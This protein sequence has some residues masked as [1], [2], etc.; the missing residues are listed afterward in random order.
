MNERDARTRAE[1]VGSLLRSPEVQQAVASDDPSATAV[2]D[3]AVLAAIELQQSAGLDVI[4][5]GETRRRSWTE[6]PRYLDCFESIAN[7]PGLR[8]RG[9]SG[10]AGVPAAGVTDVVVRRVSKA[11]RRGDRTAQYAFLAGHATA[12]TKF[13]L[14]APSYHRRYWSDEYSRS[15][16]GS[17]EEFLEEVRDHLRSVVAELISLGCDYIQC[18]APN[19]GSLCDAEHRAELTRQGHDIDAELAFDAALDNSLFDGVSG[20][21]RALHICRGNAA[22]GRWH[23]SGGYQAISGQLFGQLEFDRL[24]LE[25][26]TDRAGDFG[27]LRDVK[28]G[29]VA[30]LGLLTTKSGELEPEHLVRERL[31]EAAAV[32]PLDE[33]A[34]ST[35]CGFASVAAG[36]PVTPE[37][38]QAKLAMIGRICAD[39]WT[40]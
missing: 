27:P 9:G 12:R 21:T 7:Q 8:W 20:V 39:T 10:D 4:T 13:T 19:Y 26:D 1:T 22:G 28:P 24:M 31:A 25:Y 11:E 17:C 34:L 30:V 16:Y 40:A 35:Q 14:A 3:E 18:D 38:Q 6:T 5:D 29:V 36:N 32:K 37:Q 15:V 33:L 2:L 23:S